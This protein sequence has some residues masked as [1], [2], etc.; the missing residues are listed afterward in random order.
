MNFKEKIINALYGQAVA[1]AVGNPFEFIE[2]FSSNDVIVYANSTD[3]LVISDDTQL[4]LFGMEAI[5]RMRDELNATQ[6]Y[7]PYYTEERLGCLVKESYI[8]WYDTQNQSKSNHLDYGNCI[9]AFESMWSTQSPGY[10]CLS[11]LKTLRDG[12]IVKN[13]SKGCGSIMRL[14][15]FVSL[16]NQYSPE[17]CIEFAKIASD[18]THKHSENATATE[19]YMNLAESIGCGLTHYSAFDNVAHISKIGEGWTAQEC[20]DMAEWA[21]TKADTFDD[22]LRLSITHSGDSDSV[23]AVAGS[24]WGLSGREVPQKYIDKLDAGDAIKY[25]IDKME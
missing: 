17:E 15:P 18:I 12:G 6:V 3:K 16:R 2:S 19:H 25:I 11:A 4:C 8:D 20:L 10:T 13:D 14:L 7:V 21:Y 1:D 23:A 5:S 9:L 22:L 24:L